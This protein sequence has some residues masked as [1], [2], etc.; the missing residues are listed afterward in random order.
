M[1]GMNPFLA[2]SMLQKQLQS[3]TQSQRG[4]NDMQQGGGG[5]A[6]GG[7]GRSVMAAAMAGLPLSSDHLQFIQNAG[8]AFQH[9]QKH[10]QQHLANLP[11][12]AQASAVANDHN[13]H[14]L[15]QL[16]QQLQ[17]L[18]EMKHQ[19]QR[20][21]SGESSGSLAN[22]TGNGRSKDETNS[23]ASAMIELSS[24]S[25]ETSPAQRSIPSKSAFGSN[26]KESIK[27]RKKATVATS[28]ATA[29]ATATLTCKPV[30]QGEQGQPQNDQ[31]KQQQLL[32]QQQ[33][34]QQ[35]LPRNKFP[36]VPCRARGMPVDHSFKVCR[37]HLH[38]SLSD[39]APAC[40]SLYL[41]SFVVQPALSPYGLSSGLCFD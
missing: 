36:T 14:L 16:Q 25:N 40:L 39:C 13:Y 29:W 41:Y 23:A 17:Q 31:G 34:Q 9:Q 12:E 27:N 3:S 21:L 6:G 28:R 11:H 26:K 35:Q 20:Q 22:G 10:Q 2:S 5:S 24:G 15:Q 1:S 30:A 8:I 37:T 7:A 33:Q 32:Q 4:L 38:S 19:Q 18:Q